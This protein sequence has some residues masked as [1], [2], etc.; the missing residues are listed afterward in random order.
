MPC[1]ACRSHPGSGLAR[2]A[3]LTKIGCRP[4]FQALTW[5]C[6]ALQASETANAASD[7]TKEATNTASKK[8]G[9]V[10]DSAKGTAKDAQGTASKKANETQNTDASKKVSSPAQSCCIICVCC[11]HLKLLPALLLGES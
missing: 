10:A 2:P 7:K 1:Q 5:L 4:G 11:C 8:A 3:G 9:E 6:R